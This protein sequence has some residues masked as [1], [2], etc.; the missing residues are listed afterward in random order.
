MEA[1]KHPLDNDK[2]KLA[3]FRNIVLMQSLAEVLD[4]L[5][6]TPVYRQSVKNRCRSLSADLMEFLKHFIGVYYQENEDD[7][8]L[9]SRGID[10]VTEAL[11]TW[12]PSQMMVLE[13]VL[14]DIER[15]FDEAQKINAESGEVLD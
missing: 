8:L 14:I 11:S 12:H 5:E 9:I 2:F 10:K 1:T 6:N 3:L 4:D 15:Q 7:M 13:E